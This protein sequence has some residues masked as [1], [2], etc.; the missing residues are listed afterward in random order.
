MKIKNKENREEE[1][2]GSET[3]A[4]LDG[5]ERD[6]EPHAQPYTHNKSRS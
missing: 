1:R 4:D 2:N 3:E 6:R 5:Q